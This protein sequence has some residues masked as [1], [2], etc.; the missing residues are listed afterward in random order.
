MKPVEVLEA[1]RDLIEQA[2]QEGWDTN[3][4]ADVLNRGRDAFAALQTVMADAFEEGLN[5]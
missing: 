5:G 2:E 4:N 1:L 3:G